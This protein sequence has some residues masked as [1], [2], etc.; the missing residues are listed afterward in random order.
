MK[1]NW[2][3]GS[4]L[5]LVLVGCGDVSVDD[6]CHSSDECADGGECL[7][8]H[9]SF[10][11]VKTCDNTAIQCD[12][13][14]QSV[15]LV[16]ADNDPHSLMNV[17]EECS[18]GQ[19]CFESGG[20]AVCGECVSDNECAE[21]EAGKKCNSEYRCVQCIDDASC[22]D[23]FI[24]N[25]SWQCVPGQTGSC[26]LSVECEERAPNQLSVKCNGD[27]VDVIPCPHG[28][29]TVQR[30]GQKTIG[31]CKSKE[32]ETNPECRSYELVCS[33]ESGYIDLK[34]DGDVYANKFIRC[35]TNELCEEGKC[36]ARPD[37]DAVCENPEWVK[38]EIKKT[39]S[40]LGI[41]DA[42][43]EEKCGKYVMHAG[44][45]TAFNEAKKIESSCLVICGTVGVSDSDNEKGYELGNIKYVIG[46]NHAVIR[47]NSENNELTHPLF[48]EIK[49]S[50]VANLELDY[51]LAIRGGLTEN[52]G[53]LAGKS[54]HSLFSHI[55]LNGR[56]VSEN[57]QGIKQLGGLIG[58]SSNDTYKNIVL[59]HF[60][61]QLEEPSA[62]DKCKT[63]TPENKD[64]G[65]VVGNASNSVIENVQID[66]LTIDCG[67]G[68][69]VGGIA[70]YS[71]NVT[72]SGKG[73][74]AAPDISNVFIQKTQQYA[75]GLIGRAGGTENNI[76]NL[77]VFI[78][79]VE[80]LLQYAGGIIGSV[81]GES[82]NHL[83]DLKVHVG[84]VFAGRH[85]GGMLAMAD[86]SNVTIENVEMMSE[87][88]Q[89]RQSV[90]NVDGDKGYY[91]GGVVGS[92]RNA[93]KLTI[94]SLNH[95]FNEIRATNY[96][97]G[98]LAGIGGSKNSTG[99]IEFEDI[100]NRSSSSNG[101]YA[102]T[103]YAAGVIAAAGIDNI[104]VQ[105]LVLKN[106]INEVNS[107]FSP[108]LAGGLVA[109]ILFANNDASTCEISNIISKAHVTTN[110]SGAGFIGEFMIPEKSNGTF[111]IHNILATGSVNLNKTIN[112]N[113]S[114]NVNIG[115]AFDKIDYW[116]NN[117]ANPLASKM[118][119]NVDVKNNNNTIAYN[120][121]AHTIT[122]DDATS[123]PGVDYNL[124]DSNIEEKSIKERVNTIFSKV[125]YTFVGLNCNGDCKNQGDYHG[126][127]EYNT[128]EYTNN[129]INNLLCFG[130][131]GACNDYKN[132]NLPIRNCWFNDYTFLKNAKKCSTWSDF[133]TPI[134]PYHPYSC[135]EDDPAKCQPPCSKDVTENCIDTTTSPNNIADVLA[136][137]NQ[138]NTTS[139]TQCDNLQF[140][141][142]HGVKFDSTV[143]PYL[144]C[145]VLIGKT[146]TG[147]NTKK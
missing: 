77:S 25:S 37:P 38:T 108:K 83:H 135:K 99:S 127:Y 4:A 98:I 63:G 116:K 74:S 24:C 59:N 138:D 137:L 82:E 110:D 130:G 104:Y 29:M 70:G 69:N 81:S 79:T 109:R 36:V 53:M 26:E 80:S 48:T 117:T 27:E 5:A 97:A 41:L 141:V 57:D 76:S 140:K 51:T 144:L 21:H 78:N 32:N 106:I 103:N 93:A 7:D 8:G 14:Q 133:Y 19:R 122:H 128:I 52:V 13:E 43:I 72:I 34:C 129:Q 111:Q 142:N 39:L 100:I 112:S 85:A 107:I 145:P 89:A 126:A 61:I 102:S 119:I 101:V 17:I 143:Y 22:G 118:L 64:I 86:K 30:D 55:D 114:A 105:S 23:N 96:A 3:L 44:D 125:F 120:K 2:L 136:S 65:G 18:S 47:S 84:S 16:C 71:K 88:V 15:V 1:K 58:N 139:W 9:C 124:K 33:S 42:V 49:N 31:V 46:V 115:G 60:V 94:K 68:T 95:S 10:D 12:E 67:Y 50:T 45:K 28:C 54:D 35:D 134:L 87:T 75:G 131:N 92:I 121:V 66:G 132:R 11:G 20:N 56:I 147:M 62:H 91:A 6:T 113:V 90:C 146:Y 40:D 123:C 73:D